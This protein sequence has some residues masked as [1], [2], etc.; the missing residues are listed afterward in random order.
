MRDRTRFELLEAARGCLALHDGSQDDIVDRSIKELRLLMERFEISDEE[1]YEFENALAK[2]GLDALE[3]QTLERLL[4]QLKQKRRPRLRR[5]VFLAPD[6]STIG[7]IQNRTRKILKHAASREVSY[8]GL[9]VRRRGKLFVPDALCWDDDPESVL[10][11]IERWS[12]RE[13]V[14]VFPNNTL[15]VVPKEM[16]RRLESLPLLF[17]G[18][19]QLSFLI[20]DSPHLSNL[21]YARSVKA[22][23]CIVLSEADR[24][25]YRQF[26]LHGRIVGFHPVEVRTE[27]PQPPSS[28]AIRFGYVGRIDFY[29]K[30]ADRLIEAARVV[31]DFD[32][33]NLQVFTPDLST[34]SPDLETLT[35]MLKTEGLHESVSFI[36]NKSQLDHLYSSIDVLLLPSRKDSFPNVVLESFSFGVPVVATSYSPGAD[37]IIDHGRT[38]FLLDDF[39][40]AELVG[41]LNICDMSTLD[42]LAREA[43]AEHSRYGMGEYFRFIEQVGSEALQDFF[44]WNREPVFPELAPI[45]RLDGRLQSEQARLRRERERRKAAAARARDLRSQLRIQRRDT[46]GLRQQFRAKVAENRRLKESFRYQL[47]STIA[48]HGRTFSGLFSLPMAL[49]L[50][51]RRYFQSRR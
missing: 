31:R 47:G 29:T 22:T 49:T 36:Y 24:A 32:L 44:G 48:N 21:E 18:S 46:R 25:T 27:P 8:A 3:K 6:L 17:L 12:P 10:E 30:G 7:G 23:R 2:A 13:T 11:E 42:S 51:A 33:P 4:Y 41:V 39:S 43:F 1:A 37:R 20:Q 45:T 38:G 28:T 16:R 50:I 40:Y 5:I 34:N 35:R 19:G 26:G 14:V 9:S 15:K